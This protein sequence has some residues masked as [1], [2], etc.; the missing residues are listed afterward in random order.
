MSFEALFAP[1]HVGA[2]LLPNRIAQSALSSGYHRA[3]DVSDRHLA[4]YETRARA[5]AAMIVTE[6]LACHSRQNPGTRVA[7]FR[8]DSLEGLK[9]WAGAVEPHGARL[10]G[11]FVDPGRGRHHPGRSAQAIGASALPDD[12]SWTVPHALTPA[13]ISRLVA[14]LAETAHRLQRAGFSGVELSCGHG[15]L[16]HQFLSPASNAR[17]DAYG[18]DLDGRTRILREILAAI[19]AACGENF[20]VGMKLPGDDGVAGGI[21]PDAAALIAQKF[22]ATGMADY[23]AV[24]QGAHARSLEMHVPDRTYPKLA[25]RAITRRV[26]AASGGVPVFAVGR[27]STPEEAAALLA[28]GDADGVMLGR[29]M[30]ADGQW[31]AKARDGRT[32]DIRLCLGCNTCWESI[33]EGHGLACVVNPRIATPDEASEPLRA[34]AAKRVVVVGAGVAGLE[35]AW[36]AAARGHQVTLL[37]D[38]TG[39]KMA[40]HARLPGA[41]QLARLPDWQLRRAVNAGV[42]LRLGARADAEA[43]LALRPDAVVLATGSAMRVPEG[44]RDLR[45]VVR[46]PPAHGKLCVLYDADHT[47]GTYDAAEWLAEKFE[48]VLLVTPREMIA[49]DVSLVVRQRILRRLSLRRLPITLLHELSA[50]AAGT[51]TFR[52]VY[53]NDELRIAAIDLLACAT[54][55]APNDLLVPAL[56][57]AGI[58]VRVVGDAFAPRGPLEA[59]AEGHAAGLAV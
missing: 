53:N 25:Y 5:G 18:G 26:R 12:L 3:H 58:A 1:L 23:F 41:E 24:A 17:D 50:F 43:V 2:H 49:R 14:E 33:I 34:A 57:A 11:Q 35:A 44:A 28:A 21:D 8:E 29:A 46:A 31:V 37:G 9:R 22:A 40:L 47:V 39:G 32:Q 19:R 59:V 54:P 30:I 13:E 10:V 56:E 15:H 51:A 20:I 4:F 27:V 45:D 16:F 38:G 6:A 48:R 52:Q 7:A 55:R 42:S 36:V